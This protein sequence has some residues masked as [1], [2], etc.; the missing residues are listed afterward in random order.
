MPSILGEDPRYNEK[1]NEQ[2]AK[3]KLC[4]CAF[5]R[6]CLTVYSQI[7]DNSCRNLHCQMW[8]AN[9]E[10]TERENYQNTEEQLQREKVQ[11]KRVPLNGV[12][13]ESLSMSTNLSIYCEI[14][15][16]RKY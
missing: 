8:T 10:E 14:I 13:V 4:L 15:T 12:C 6:V 11:F 5:P 7:L 2:F 16:M 3:R 1:K 9:V